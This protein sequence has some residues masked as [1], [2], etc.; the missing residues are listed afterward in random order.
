MID[1]EQPIQVRG[2][3]AA[4]IAAS[5]EAG[6]RDGVLAPGSKLPPV[7]QLAGQLGVSPV[8]VSAA[9]RTLRGRGLVATD[10]RRGTRVSL[11]PP[12]PTRALAPV[13]AGVRNL[14][15]G[16]PDRRLLPS[17]RSALDQ[18]GAEPRLYG[19]QP[20]LGALVD[21]ARQRFLA[22]DVPADAVTVVAGAHDGFERVL[23]AHLRQGDKIAIEDPGHANLLDLVGALGIKPEP[24]P[25]DDSGLIPDEL[26]R[27]LRAGAR[28]VFLTPRAQN[29][30]GAM[31]DETRTRELRAV[32]RRFPETLVVE[33][34]HSPGI[35]GAAAHTLVDRRLTRWA[36]VRGVSKTL[37]PDLRLAVLAGDATTVARVTGRRLL[38]AGWVSGIVQMLVLEL[39]SDPDVQALIATAAKTYAERRT[40]LVDALSEQGI[41]A[42]GQSGFNVWI[43]VADER[44][45]VGLLLDAGWAVSPG[46]RFRVASPPGLRVT[47]ASL[48]PDDA[49][50]FASDMARTLRPGTSSYGA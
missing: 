1:T 30:T 26:E 28:A 7:R 2:R 29:P 42:R 46:E 6:V 40:A 13:P 33:D 38:G 3:N 27:A 43:P 22:D 14:A 10:G 49:R 21:L 20:D 41:P 9:Y 35:A 12:L 47:A 32:L 50:R 5:I 39:W 19:E 44:T 36:V 45:P 48:H 17:L 18:V 31:L 4:D 24:V 37:G 25:V 11:G 34:D 8:T 23:S 15:D 16:N